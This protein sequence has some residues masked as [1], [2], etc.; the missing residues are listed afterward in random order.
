MRT[1]LQNRTA[2]YFVQDGCLVRI[3]AGKVPMNGAADRTYTHRCA[4]AVFETVAHAISETPHEG[5]GTS[6][7]RIVRQENLPHTQVNVALEFLKERGLV[8]V[9][10]RHCYPTTEDVYLDAMIEYHAL[11]DGD[12][13]V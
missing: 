1:S 13:M 6:L 7:D 2:V 8:E 3:V 4:K 12:K 5:D 10:H 11:A 9:R